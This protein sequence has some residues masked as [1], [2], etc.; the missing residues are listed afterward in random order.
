MQLRKRSLL[1]MI[2]LLLALALGT[3]TTQIIVAGVAGPD[4]STSSLSVDKST[5][6][7]GNTVKYTVVVN[8]TGDTVA[9]NVIVTNTLPDEVTYLA[10]SFN[11]ETVGATTLSHSDS[12]NVITWSGDVESLGSATLTYSAEVADNVALDQVITNKVEIAG[13]GELF[14][15][16]VGTVVG[17]SANTFMPLVFQPIP[18]PVLS[19][20]TGP[21]ASSNSWDATWNTPA[22][23][24][25]GYQV[26]EAQTSSFT[27]PV[28]Y[29]VG[30]V[31]SRTFSYPA[32]ASNYYCYRVRALVGSLA[33]DWSNVECAVG[34][35]NDDFTNSGSGWMLRQEDTDDTENSTYYENNQF[36]VK[37][38][39]RWDYALASPLAQAPKPP[40]AIET[41]IRFDESVDNL[42]GYG[43]VFGGNWNGQ[44]CPNGSNY[45]NCFTHYYRFLVVWYGPL[46]SFRIQ[47]KRIDYNDTLDNIGRGVTL[48]GF[49][50]IYVPNSKGFNVWRV[51]VGADGGIRIL[52]N[53]SQ[54]MSVNDS[55][56][57]NSP[58]F[59]VMASSDEYLGAEPHL[60]WYRVIKQ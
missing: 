48:D 40:Y 28:I 53:G 18:T 3:I 20:I 13:E 30:N 44:P 41:S 54:V 50:D 7:A 19:S 37:I 26:Q 35:Y 9:N 1:V 52:L 57:I 5:T 42:H 16:S 25:T 4:L 43:I 14:E 6:I 51:E 56:Y 21:T 60:D 33:G 24:I 29:D 12:G 23:E 27:N 15:Q 17:S 55:T 10:D 2:Y 47:L 34:N 36:V 8:N 39:G 45:G 59:G 58:Y 32:T 31:N 11:S 38:G 49:K 46:D 22:P